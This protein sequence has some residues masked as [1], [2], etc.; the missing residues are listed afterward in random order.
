MPTIGENPLIA[1]DL[2]REELMT[3]FKKS[4][5]FEARG[6]RAVIE[7]HV[8]TQMGLIKPTADSEA[9]TTTFR[10]LKDELEDEIKDEIEM[11]ANLRAELQNKIRT[12]RL[13]KDYEALQAKNSSLKEKA[14][15][16]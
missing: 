7:K 15:A 14:Q 6:V 11:K 4:L 2:E 16:L 8:K 3:D 5:H 12:N 10:K 13:N 9:Q 1:M